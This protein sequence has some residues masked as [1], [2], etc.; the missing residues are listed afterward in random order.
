MLKKVLDTFS[1]RRSRRMRRFHRSAAEV[2]MCLSACLHILGAEA[3]ERSDEAH[4]AVLGA[5]SPV[6]IYTLILNPK[7]TS[8]AALPQIPQFPKSG[9]LI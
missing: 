3:E 4:D 7:S 6:L 1:H 8:S 5:V 2:K 9:S